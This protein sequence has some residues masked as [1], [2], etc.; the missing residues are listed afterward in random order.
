MLTELDHRRILLISAEPRLTRALLD[1]SDFRSWEIVA[2]ESSAAAALLLQNNACDIILADDSH[3][4]LEGIEGLAWLV[5]KQDI[6]V[7]LLADARPETITSAY[8]RG[9]T[10][11]LPL[12]QCQLV[13]DL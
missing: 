1:L 2:A 11:W 5:T 10:L 4:R 7:V 12:R 9:L 3:F 6:P 13:P 8:A